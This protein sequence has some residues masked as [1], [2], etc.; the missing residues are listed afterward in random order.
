MQGIQIEGTIRYL[1]FNDKEEKQ[2]KYADKYGEKLKGSSIVADIPEVYNIQPSVL[3][4]K[5]IRSSDTAGFGDK[6]VKKFYLMIQLM[7]QMMQV[8][9]YG[10]QKKEKWEL[11]V[12]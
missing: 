10:Y 1:L 4:N 9:N 12:H 2:K 5:P 8:A 11:Y 3:F 6:K 7:M